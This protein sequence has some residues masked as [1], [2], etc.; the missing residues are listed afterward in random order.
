MNAQIEN[1]NDNESY[2]SRNGEWLRPAIAGLML[3]VA[4][5]LVATISNGEMP[6]PAWIPMIA[7]AIAFALSGFYASLCETFSAM[8]A[9]VFGQFMAVTL[10][11]WAIFSRI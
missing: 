5:F 8:F 10:L 2:F 3:L 7:A 1:E 9:R 6:F 11:L 4:P